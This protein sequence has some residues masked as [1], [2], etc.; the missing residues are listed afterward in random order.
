LTSIVYGCA[1]ASRGSTQVVLLGTGIVLLAVFVV[2][3][4]RVPAPLLPLRILRD[5]NRVGA[6]LA[7]AFGVAGM[8]ATFLFLTYYLQTV[9]GYSPL[10][11]GLAF[12]PLSA[13]VFA[14]SQL[15]AARLQAHLPPRVL[16]TSGLLVAA[17]ALGLLT[18]LSP[19]GTYA[20]DV[21]PAEVLLGLGMGCVFAPA[22]SVATHQVD[23]R[24]A[25][26]A[27]AVVNTAQQ[28]G[29]SIGVAVL[30][31][32]AAGAAAGVRAAGTSPADA[33]V[34]GYTAAAFWAALTLAAGALVSAVLINAT[35]PKQRPRRQK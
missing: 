3:E 25:G 18:G 29:G 16:I 4:A 19:T 8:L 10:Q 13:A 22:I 32:V 11:A 5:R 21:L 27:A 30:N 14:S 17:A 23:P 28:V 9:L 33:L 1:Q 35:A 7:V 12:L 6:Y 26:V 31:T 24:D 34:A 15:L 2:W 20:T